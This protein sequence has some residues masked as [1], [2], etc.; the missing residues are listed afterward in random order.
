MYVFCGFK[1][2]EILECKVLAFNGFK[3]VT[4]EVCKKIHNISTF[5]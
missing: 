2:N 5:A 1:R 4:V 3:N